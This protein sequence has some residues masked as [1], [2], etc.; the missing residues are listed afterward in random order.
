MHIIIDE[1]ARA[2]DDTKE[3]IETVRDSFVRSLWI[4]DM[5]RMFTSHSDRE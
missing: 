2:L 4:K 3:T 5:I 1:L